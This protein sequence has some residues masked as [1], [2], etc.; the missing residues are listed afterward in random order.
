MKEGNV[1]KVCRVIALIAATA[2]L[3]SG[4]GN[5]KTDTVVSQGTVTYPANG[6]YPVSSEDEL[7]LWIPLTA[8]VSAQVS[9][10]G[11]TPLAKEMEKVI[12]AKVTYIHPATGM[13]KEQF[14]LLLASD[15]M[16]DIISYDW[17]KYGGDK[18]IDEG[19]IQPLRYRIFRLRA[20]SHNTLIINPTEEPEYEVGARAEITSYESKPRGTKIV[21]DMSKMLAKNAT[22]A[23]RGFL[24][25]DDRTSL[26]VRDELV[27]PK[28]SD[29]YWHMYT[30]A[31]TE[32]EGNAVILTDTADSG[33]QV[34]LEFVSN[35]A[36]EISV[37]PASPL[38][39]AP[40]V[41]GQSSNKDFQRIVYKVK[42]NG[43]LNITA[44]LTPLAY[45]G[46]SVGDY[47]VPI[48]T[49]V[50]PDGE[51]ETLPTLDKLVIGGEVYDPEERFITISCEN[52]DSPV[53]EI[54]A[55]SEKYDV[56]IVRG[57]SV[58]DK[59]YV[60]LS[61]PKKPDTKYR[62][63]ISFNPQKM[64]RVIEGYEEAEIRSVTATD[65]PQP[66]NVAINVLDGKFSTRWSA[67]REQSLLLELEKET[68]IDTY[69]M[70]MYSGNT[71]QTFFD[72][73]VSV[74][75]IN[76]EKVYSGATSGTTSDYETYDIGKHT[77]KY[78][79]VDFHGASNSTWNSVTE[80]VAAI[81]K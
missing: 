73:S 49:W 81:K 44:K 32:I 4:C 1:N 40:V 78:I 64:R 19:Y 16:P 8:V 62:Y 12:G 61:D 74:D 55:A 13:E 11:D 36:G 42:G 34:K 41:S 2:M 9:N 50:I 59:T 31:K 65:E 45:G 15:G 66:D 80:V 7:S 39:S 35:A 57:E 29:V 5:K 56:E 51:Q 71:R 24:F 27:L 25:T 48:S 20:A 37:E 52:E 77:V 3:F 47:D 22:S 60:L 70:S 43:N 33:K 23:T 18:A 10:F 17:Y 72:V 58:M 76:Y 14:N 38:E 75:G 79:R 21:I 30:K 69:I 68:E 53:P 63:T 46:S 28:A 6:T 54:E 67:E 26:V